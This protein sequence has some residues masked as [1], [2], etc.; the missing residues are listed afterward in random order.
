MTDG[1]HPPY[2]SPENNRAIRGAGERS[3]ELR[4]PRAADQE[5]HRD[6]VVEAMI[7][8]PEPDERGGIASVIRSSYLQQ[9]TTGSRAP[10]WLA[11]YVALAG[12]LIDQAM[13]L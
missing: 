11:A 10:R 4:H 6:L 5:K 13:R 2:L 12:W 1:H 9:A 7:P 8:P 3:R